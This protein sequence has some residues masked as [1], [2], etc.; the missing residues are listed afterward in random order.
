M[1]WSPPIPG[2]AP[3]SIAFPRMT[4]PQLFLEWLH[5]ELVFLE[6]LNYLADLVTHLFLEQPGGRLFFLE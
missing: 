3:S 5:P 4:G 2:M 1:P 6:R